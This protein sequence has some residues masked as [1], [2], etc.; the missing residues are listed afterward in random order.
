MKKALLTLLLCVAVV[1]A[2]GLATVMVAGLRA[3][4]H[5][6]EASM[7]QKEARVTQVEVKVLEP[8]RVEDRLVLTGGVQPWQEVVVS[9]EARGKI[10]EQGV[11]EGQ[12]VQSGQTLVKVDTSMLK[13]HVDQAQARQRLAQQDMQR[14]ESLSSKQITSAQNLDQTRAQYEMA[15][16]DLRL[17]SIQFEKGVVA[18]PFDG[19]I[20]KLFKE[21]REFV[22]VGTPLVRLVQVHRVKVCVGIPERDIAFFSNGDTVSVHVDALPD[23]SFE[24]VIESVATTAEPSTLTFQAEVAVEN[25]E[26]VL[27]PGMIA[28]ASLV[29]R[30]YEDSVVAP[31]FSVLSVEN[32][33]FV[34]V[35]RD[36]VAEARPIEVGVIQ[37]DS[38]QVTKG[39]SPGERLIVVGQRDLKPGDRVAVAEES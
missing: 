14:I 20:D 22:D 17:A 15:E 39:L 23:R 35:E 12:V 21:E 36:G 8:A 6:A 5:R 32:Q 38:V 30:T 16:A 18:A 29:R 25:P 34:F 10:E 26:G 11:K 2:G 13:A 4:A 28:R 7:P 27:K 3:K 37:G 33:R 31:I 1:G 24:G 9:S 19:V